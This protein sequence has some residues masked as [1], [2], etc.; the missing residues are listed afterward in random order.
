MNA[1]NKSRRSSLPKLELGRGLEVSFGSSIHKKREEQGGA[2][3]MDG[4]SLDYQCMSGYANE[5][6]CEEDLS[7]D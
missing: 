2:G 5:I 4:I 6:S 3:P 1:S 7:R